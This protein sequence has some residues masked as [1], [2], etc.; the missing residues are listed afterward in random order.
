MGATH[1]GKAELYK[2]PSSEQDIQEADANLAQAKANLEQAKLDVENLQAGLSEADVALLE[3]QLADAKRSYE[4]VKDG[5]NPDDVATLEARIAAAQA[6]INSLHITAPFDGEI[7]VLNN[8]AGDVINAG[9]I[10]VV[11]ANRQKLFVEV[12]VDESD[13]ASVK[14]GDLAEITVM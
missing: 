5:P 8:A 1:I 11:V 14:Q 2:A 10:A 3:A 9:D 12:Q 4:L 13:I 7:L 6:T